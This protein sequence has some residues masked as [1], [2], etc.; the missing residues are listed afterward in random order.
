MS[1]FIYWLVIT[2]PY[3]WVFALHSRSFWL[4][5][6]L[7]YNNNSKKKKE[8]FMYTLS[9]GNAMKRIDLIWYVMISIFF[10]NVL[11]HYDWLRA[12]DCCW[13]F[14]NIYEISSKIFFLLRKWHS[15]G[16]VLNYSYNGTINWFCSTVVESYSITNRTCKNKICSQNIFKLLT[17]KIIFEFFNARIK[18]KFFNVQIKFEFST[19]K[20]NLNLKT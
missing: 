13:I 12:N 15:K 7:S 4:F 14:S 11:C 19:Y 9:Y 17:Y 16:Y 8:G 6:Q 2:C 10:G 1:T 5:N 3:A 18:F 20:L